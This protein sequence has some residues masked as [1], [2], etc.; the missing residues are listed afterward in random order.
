M[1]RL[2]AALESA[3]VRPWLCEVDID[4]SENFVA[5]I[6]AGLEQCDISLVIWSPDAAASVWTKEEWTSVLARQVS[7]QRIRLG[8]VLLRDCVLPELL[9][10]KNYIDA[11]TDQEAGIRETVQWLLRR[12]SV[13]RLSGLKAPV[14]LPDYRPKDFVGR[15]EY[16]RRLRE[17]LVSEPGAF[18]LHGGPGTGKSMLALRFAWDAQ[19][20]FDAVVYQP[21]GARELDVI[22]TE[23]A[24]RL[25]IDVKAQPL[26]E[27]RKEAMR[28]LR[29]RQS[30]LVLDDI[31][32]LEVR[33]LEPGPPTSVLYTSRKASLPWIPEEQSLEVKSFCEDEAE[34]LFH[35]FLDSVF[36]K[37]EVTRNS[38]LLLGF[39]EKVGMLPIAVAVAASLLRG[40]RASRLDS[41][42]LKLRL[43]SLHDGVRDVRQL[44]QQA[45]AT[46]P[47]RGQELLAASAVCPPEAFWMPLAARIAD[48]GADEADDVADELVNSS[49][50]RVLNREGRQFQLHALMREEIRA[51][52]DAQ[53][54]ETLQLRHV[55]ALLAL[56]RWREL[57]P[58][59]LFSEVELASKFLTAKGDLEKTLA[60]YKKQEE[61]WVG[62]DRKAYLPLTYSAQ[63]QFLYSM[64][65]FEEV[66]T[67]VE[68][69]EVICLEV[70]DKEA[71]V[72]DY[73]LKALAL[74]A[75][76][77][78]EEALAILE[79][80]EA[81]S[82]ELKSK[83]GL[84]VCYPAYQMILQECGQTEAALTVLQK[85]EAICLELSDKAG[86]ALC[87]STW[88]LLASELGDRETAKAKFRRSIELFTEL[89]RHND[90]DTVQAML[91]DL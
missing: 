3:A 19:K 50:M 72:R 21:C 88:G 48:F 24:D 18:L 36:G 63:A 58:W 74:R 14:Y 87:Y 5:K 15:E 66:V 69:Q 31:W 9:R 23:L 10:T 42:A 30:L 6:E 81:I 55:E 7:E 35:N 89:N 53:K 45:I 57:S 83:E 71:L 84:L 61:I 37:A 91:N 25:P 1:Q 33:Q 59:Q 16:L 43:D 79:K 13:Q 32:N 38:S 17:M 54:L 41:S 11:R 85:L 60:V 46:Q 28:W 12:E 29:E 51:G 47:E 52:C 82:V 78:P 62:L 39:A 80:Q 75:L 26:E 8:I 56:E 34:L 4:K 2:A 27:K 68:K 64:Q 65:R 67:L 77:R 86:L 73:V 20:D 70:G 44:F 40:K 49:L 22:T 76:Q 90:R